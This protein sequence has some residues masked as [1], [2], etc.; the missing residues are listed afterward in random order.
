M[1]L[2]TM[3]WGSIVG[4]LLAAISWNAGANY[5]LLLDLVVSVGAIV[6]V[7]H[8]IRAR[9]YFWASAFVGMA[10]LLN[11]IVPVFTPAGN[12][13]LLLFLVGMSPVVMTFAALVD[14]TITLYPNVITDAYSQDELL[15][16]TREWAV[17]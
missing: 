3:K 13:M 11:P 8:A 7:R 14:A 2:K 15:I 5:R 1:L 4:L 9:Q 10:L 12:L 16:P 17:V 6:V